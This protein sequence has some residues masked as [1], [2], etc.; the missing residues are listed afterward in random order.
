MAEQNELKS[1]L[2][3]SK[4]ETRISESTEDKV[5]KLNTFCQTG[6]E[7]IKSE[8]YEDALHHLQN[9][10]FSESLGIGFGDSKALFLN[11]DLTKPEDVEQVL[12]FV[13]AHSHFNH[14]QEP[15]LKLAGL[16][17]SNPQKIGEKYFVPQNVWKDMSLVHL[18]EW[19]HATQFISGKPLAGEND[20]ELDVALY[21]KRKGITLTNHFLE[22]H[23]RNQFFKEHPDL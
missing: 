8:K 15:E 6:I 5:N 23:G 14:A 17:N 21:M 11:H 20:N 18:E 16:V 19:L 10:N 1:E 22:M 12:N 7:L 13:S 9:S 3:S 4:P 2:A